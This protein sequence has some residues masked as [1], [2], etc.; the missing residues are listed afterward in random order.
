MTLAEQLEQ[1]IP[2]IL[3][4]WEAHVRSAVAAARHESRPVL[5]NSIPEFLKELVASLAG[6]DRSDASKR[7]APH[8][9]ARQRA[10]HP[11]YSLEQVVQE[12]SLLRAT[13]LD[14]LWPIGQPDLRII[15]DIID[16]AVAE[17]TTRY[18]ELQASALRES[19]ER[20]RLLVGGVKDYA[21]FMLDTEGY[22]VTWNRGAER[23]TGHAADEAT[24]QHVS[25][26][27][28]PEERDAGAPEHSLQA[29]AIED[30]LET[31]GWRV[32]KDGT[33]LWRTASSTQSATRTVR[34]AASR[35]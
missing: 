32:R 4:Q 33:R 35:R 23:I 17:A 28:T 5:L 31:E 16:A 15:L 29:A 26:F 18:A 13:I 21:I 12:Y 34:S 8:E 20:F 10:E 19:E 30:R 7:L 9:H 3:R 11:D 27:Y 25:T 1:Q 14:V 6:V 24:G 22:V 2:E